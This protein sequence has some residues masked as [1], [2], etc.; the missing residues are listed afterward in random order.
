MDD[1]IKRAI[2]ED[3]IARR[4][5]ECWQAQRQRQRER[6]E[7]QVAHAAEQR[8]VG[9]WLTRSNSG[10]GSGGEI[11]ENDAAWN[12][13]C[14]AIARGEA[15]KAA[16]EMNNLLVDELNKSDDALEARLNRRKD[17]FEKRD[18]DLQ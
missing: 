4:A 7:R 16:V 8:A 17:H 5:F 1:I 9:E 6:E 12:E 2:I 11:T 18:T 10:T 15:V 14:K 13:W 3:E